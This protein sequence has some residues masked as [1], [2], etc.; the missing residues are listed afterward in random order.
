MKHWLAL[1]LFLVTVWLYIDLVI[2]GVPATHDGQNHLGR[3]ANYYVAVKQGQIP[4]RLA[5]NLNYGYGYPVFNYN[6]PLA[7]ILGV[8]LIAVGLSVEHSFVLLHLA[9]L[10]IAYWAM[11]RWLAAYLGVRA[12]AVGAFY[13]ATAPYALTLV[14]VRG[15][16]GELFI[17]GLL[18]VI[19]YL[20]RAMGKNTNSLY[21][22]ILLGFAGASLILSHNIM[23]LFSS[24]LIVVYAGMENAWKITKFTQYLPSL[25][26]ALLLS[27]F[28]WLPAMGEK[29]WVV[30]DESS[31]IGKYQDHFVTLAELTYHRWDYGLSRPGPVDGIYLGVGLPSLVLLV[32]IAV[33]ILKQKR[34]NSQAMYLVGGLVALGFLV[35]EGSAIVWNLVP[36]VS[37]I[38]FPWRLLLFW[39]LLFSVLLAW[40]MQKARVSKWIVLGLLLIL[41]ISTVSKSR[42]YSTIAKGDE[43]WMVFPETTTVADENRPHWFDRTRVYERTDSYF[44]DNSLYIE[45][46]GSYTIESWNGSKHVYQL[47]LPSAATIIE[48]AMYFPGWQLRVNGTRQQIAYEREELPGLISYQL[49]PGTYDVETRFTQHTAARMLGN[50]ITISG[51]VLAGWWFYGSRK[52]GLKK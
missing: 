29:K 20:I 15:V 30:L 48:R 36:S 46:N 42:S 6:Y 23:A 33:W 18:P 17:Y 49:G 24:V 40:W 1:I 43:H 7:N 13:Y 41:F 16:I 21:V 31:L 14:Y 4:P 3:M 19:L 52:L 35:W 47:N 28:F 51:L 38:Q 25:V 45:G 27:A 9:A 12:A 39:P 32:V 5:P 34:Y 10:F 37:Y 8:P 50:L 44:N 11:Y 26:L 2:A 22:P